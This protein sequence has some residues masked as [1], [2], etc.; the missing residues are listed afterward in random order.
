M[1]KSGRFGANAE[2]GGCLG[3]WMTTWQRGILWNNMQHSTVKHMQ[4]VCA[5]C[6]CPLAS[7]PRVISLAAGIVHP[8]DELQIS[9]QY[10]HW[11]G[12]G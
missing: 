10:R 12:G 6:S 8:V 3:P 9:L 5:R 11:G 1:V 2:A 7:A 4:Q